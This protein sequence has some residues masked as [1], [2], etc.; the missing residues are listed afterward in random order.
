M[1]NS[2][3]RKVELGLLMICLFLLVSISLELN[4]LQEIA[5]YSII[6][7]LCT[8]VGNSYVWGVIGGIIAVVIVYFAQVKYSKWM[9]KKDFRCNEVIQDI[10]SIIEIYVDISDKVPARTKLSENEEYL[11]RRKRDATRFYEFYKKKERV[12]ELITIGLT[13]ENND[14]LIESVQSCFLINLNFKLLSI[15]NNIKNR[16]FS[17][18]QGYKEVLEMYKNYESD[19]TDQTLFALGDKLFSLF[20]DLKYMTLYWNQLFDYLE[21]D[22]TYFRLYVKIYNS[23]YS[24]EEDLR[25]PIE[26]QNLRVKE[27]NKVVKRKMLLYKIRHFWD[28]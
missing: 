23:K 9:L 8:I 5:N 2:L 27:V 25:Q 22:P 4:I 10:C 14:I 24:I 26:I 1:R 15:I 17:L 11:V 21:Y 19:K 7:L 18:R 28:K 16:L 6:N 3:Y 13:C 12:I 20:V